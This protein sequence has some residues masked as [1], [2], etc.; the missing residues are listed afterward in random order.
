MTC[1]KLEDIDFESYYEFTR[2]LYKQY[3]FV[4]R[5]ILSN[6][7]RVQ[8]EEKAPPPYPNIV[9]LEI[10]TIVEGSEVEL[11]RTLKFPFEN[12]ELW[13]AIDSLEE[14]SN[15]YWQRDNEDE[16]LIEVGGNSYTMTDGWGI[17]F[18]AHTP[19]SVKNFVDN[20]IDYFH[21]ME[22]GEIIELSDYK[23]TKIDKSMMLF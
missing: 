6:D 15:F 8:Y 22:E 20:F 10:S 13:S 16:Y 12:E 14:E 18:D 1:E 21:D 11:E 19:Q 5:L 9:G 3:G 23:I 2:S 17:E 7:A 4:S